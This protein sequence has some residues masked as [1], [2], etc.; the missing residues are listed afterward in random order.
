MIGSQ[1]WST[2]RLSPDP[3]EITQ[4]DTHG[5]VAI[6]A[7]RE[8]KERVRRENNMNGRNSYLIVGAFVS[9]GI[10]A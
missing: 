8:R 9:V 10:V 1:C 4:S 2:V 7:I 3:E 6:S 5:F